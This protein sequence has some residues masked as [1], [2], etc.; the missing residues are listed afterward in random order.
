MFSG[1]SAPTAPG[2][3]QRASSL[4]P[5]HSLGLRAGAQQQGCGAMTVNHPALGAEE[6]TAL[7]MGAQQEGDLQ[8]RM[9]AML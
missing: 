6:V 9:V 7:G 3:T 5:E 2:S 4:L 1:L 8:Q